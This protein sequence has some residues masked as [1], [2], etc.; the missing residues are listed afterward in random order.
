MTA[1]PPI[2]AATAEPEAGAEAGSSGSAAPAVNGGN[3]AKETATL[4]GEEQQSAS[5]SAEFQDANSRG[6][7][8]FGSND[9]KLTDPT[10]WGAGL[11]SGSFF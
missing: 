3:V 6:S 8:S 2:G 5:D 10:S 1:V 9:F 11:Q 4:H 7:S